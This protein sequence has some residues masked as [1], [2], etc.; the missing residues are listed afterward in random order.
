VLDEGTTNLFVRF[1]IG[2]GLEISRRIIISVGLNKDKDRIAVC[3]AMTGRTLMTSYNSL[4]SNA[5]AGFCYT[6]NWRILP[7]HRL[8]G[9]VPPGKLV[10]KENDKF[11]CECEDNW[12]SVQIGTGYQNTPFDVVYRTCLKK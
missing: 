5:S 11:D 9:A 12:N 1:D 6:A 10:E 8:R 7:N 4:P 3:K 2:K